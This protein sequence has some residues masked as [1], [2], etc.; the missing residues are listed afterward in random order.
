VDV[1][2]V[3]NEDKPENTNDFCQDRDGYDHFQ[4][5]YESLFSNNGFRRIAGEDLQ[6]FCGGP[7]GQ[8]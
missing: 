3:Q 5:H 4:N 1:R 8:Y 7:H 2:S 6:V